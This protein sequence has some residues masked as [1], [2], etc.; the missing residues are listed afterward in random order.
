MSTIQIIRCLNNCRGLMLPLTSDNLY[1]STGIGCFGECDTATYCCTVGLTA[2]RLHRLCSYFR[3]LE[4][5][6]LHSND[7]ALPLAVVDRSQDA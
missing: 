3:L 5:R 2:N 6:H 1:I 4:N 7:Y